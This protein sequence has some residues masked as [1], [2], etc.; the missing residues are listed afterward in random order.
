MSKVSLLL[1]AVGCAAVIPV[2][3]APAPLD[4]KKLSR[5]DRV[6]EGVYRSSQPSIADLAT[7]KQDYGLKSVLKLNHGVDHAPPGVTVIAH[8]LDALV[9]PSQKQI[10][11]ILDAI[12]S[13]AKPILIHCTQGQDRTGLVVALYKIRHGA[14]V[15]SAYG[16]MVRHGFRPWRGLWRYWMKAAGW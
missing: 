16:D 5:F 9:T 8:P 2:P 12:D 13:A 1:L 11:Q 6:A 10:D 3:P 7:L 4:G 15:D 14:A